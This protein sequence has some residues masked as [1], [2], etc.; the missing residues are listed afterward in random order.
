M[1]AMIVRGYGV[2]YYNQATAA[3]TYRQAVAPVVTEVGKM[4]RKL[5][6]QDE[7]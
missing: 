3:S 5:G 2:L 4:A 7:L 6:G 1:L